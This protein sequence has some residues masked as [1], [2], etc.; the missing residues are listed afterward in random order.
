M[1][2]KLILI[3]SDGGGNEPL[4]GVHLDKD[5]YLS[6]FQSP[7]GGAW[8]DSEIIIFDD[9]NFSLNSLEQLIQ[10]TNLIGQKIE[11]FLIVYC[12]HGYTDEEG[13][14]HFEVNEA[15]SMALND[16]R[17]TVCGTRCL[18]IADSCRTICRLNEG[19]I[20]DR[21]MF[22]SECQEYPAYAALC[23][24][25][26]NNF[27]LQT[28][29]SETTILLAC[30]FDEMSRENTKGG[31]YSYNLILAAK[32][33]IR[34]MRSS[35]IEDPSVTDAS[36]IACHNA[37]SNVVAERTHNKQHPEIYLRSR[38]RQQFP[39]VVVPTLGEQLGD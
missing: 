6:F 34:K 39:F 37:A 10:A 8:L 3:I 2:R 7:E 15:S 1:N 22:S 32:N 9:N 35:Q 16:L 19:G 17:E 24:E 38:A 18:F 4:A 14:I 28:D 20:L 12:G 36:A 25:K 27:I 26:Y 5:N 21:R 13:E 33:K 23:R 31:L 29:P 30:S 11:Y